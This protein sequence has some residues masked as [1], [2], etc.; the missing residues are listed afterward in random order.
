MSSEQ[1]SRDEARAGI[2]VRCLE[3]FTRIDVPPRTKEIKC[4]NCS[5][6]F[7]I[8]WPTPELAKIKGLAT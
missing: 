8:Y 1:P 2:K 7:L 3:C 4:P 5:T 6:K